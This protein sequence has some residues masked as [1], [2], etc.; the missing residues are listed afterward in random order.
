M[1]L[2]DAFSADLSAELAD[3]RKRRDLKELSASEIE[4]LASKTASMMIEAAHAREATADAKA[5]GVL[6]DASRQVQAMIAETVEAETAGLRKELQAKLGNVEGE[7]ERLLE[8]ARREAR[9][10]TSDADAKVAQ[11]RAWLR[12]QVE[13]ARKIQ[14]GLSDRLSAISETSRSHDEA[15]GRSISA[16]AE[17]HGSSDPSTQI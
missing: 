4:L 5:T 6:A 2:N 13:D 14:K 8:A 9:Q 17:L 10:I 16:L 7:K 1:S 11:Y 3:L 12:R 15:L